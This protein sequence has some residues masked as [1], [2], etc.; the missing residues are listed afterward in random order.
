MKLSFIS[1]KYFFQILNDKRMN[2]VVLTVRHKHKNHHAKIYLTSML[3][4]F[5]NIY[6]ILYP[7]IMRIY[8]IHK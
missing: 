7:N 5:F 8:T 3:A 4:F 2:P 6:I 1:L